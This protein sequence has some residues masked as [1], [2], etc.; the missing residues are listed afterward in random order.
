M[1]QADL[2]RFKAILE[3]QLEDLFK[4]AE[5]DL[6]QIKDV[7]Y[8]EIDFV[9]SAADDE[10]KNLQYRIIDR[11]SKLIKKIRS[12]LERIEDG[13]Y[14]ICEACGKDISIKRLEARPVTNKCIDCKTQE[15]RYEKPKYH[16]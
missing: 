7:D 13:T 8:R 9:D 14:G 4:E 6:K 11:E 15:E 12:A 5:L 1:E 16:Y 2:N 10:H 3:Q